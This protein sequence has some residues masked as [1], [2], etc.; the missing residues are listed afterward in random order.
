MQRT[1]SRPLAV[2]RHSAML[3]LAEIE[4]QA[5]PVRACIAELDAQIEEQER[6]REAEARAPDSQ[7]AA[8]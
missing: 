1:D 3:R 2:R 6:A 4:A 8:E 7:H 5:V